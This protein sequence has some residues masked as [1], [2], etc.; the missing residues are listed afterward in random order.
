M[1]TDAQFTAWLKDT[2][3]VR[4][5]LVYAEVVTNGGV[6]TV[7][8]LS[9]FP[10]TTSD[11][12]IDPNVSFMP[13]ITGGIKITQSISIDGSV[14]MSFGDIQLANYDGSIDS[15]LD[16][17]WSMAPVSVYVGDV[18][19]QTSDFR[20]IGI[21]VASGIDS[22]GRD[23]VNIKLS[24][25]IQR[26]NYPVSD[27]KLNDGTTQADNLIPLCFG[28]CHNV[29]PVLT[30]AATSEYQVH[31]GAIAG[32]LEVR[33]N[34]VPVSFTPDVA[35]GKFT[36]NQ[37][38]VGTITASV[39]GALLP[40]NVL[41]AN[42]AINTSAWSKL[43]TTSTVV[44]TDPPFPGYTVYGLIANTTVTQHFVYS[45]V[46][47]PTGSTVNAL[48]YFKIPPSTTTTSF[49][50]NIQGKEGG[51]YLYCE[52]T[53]STGVLFK[54]ATGVTVGGGYF[55]GAVVKDVGNGWYGLFMAGNPDPTSTTYRIRI[56]W[57]QSWQDSYAG[58]GS[59]VGIYV[60]GPIMQGG[61]LPLTSSPYNTSTGTAIYRHTIADI[62]V[63]LTTGYGSSNATN[64]FDKSTDFD[65]EEMARFILANQQPV[66]I[67]L[68][69]RTNVID[70]CNQLAS[71][72]G[73]RLVYGLSG[74]KFVKLDPNS[75]SSN[76]TAITTS[77]ILE[78]SLQISS[79]PAVEASV[80]I[81][82][83][84]NWT[85][86]DTVADGVVSEHKTLY[87]EEYLTV[88]RVDT[89][90]QTNYNLFS[91]PVEQDTLLAVDTDAISEANRRL[92]IFNTQRKILKYTTFYE[93]LFEQVGGF[94]TITHPRFGLA[95]G[96]T[97]QIVSMSF[98]LT[99]PHVDFEVLI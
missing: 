47:M 16:D 71:S 11:S 88:T 40:A 22:K 84:K 21:F 35:N 18:S 78:R 27:A 39:Q 86:Q 95:S 33:D 62:V 2:S 43:A 77:D 74:A 15:W 75:P 94:Q 60:A 13:I 7:R 97:G 4:C 54:T 80:K 51:S 28:E 96:K 99:S 98:D 26:L 68:K 45:D 58:D 91:D 24:D 73:A 34:G 50:L 1:I 93:Y 5:V 14:S 48:A 59:T 85:V 20:E 82:Y 9:N 29:S 8:R 6:P 25:Q 17:Y 69:D 64:R 44:S 55:N 46:T 70:A 56:R 57:K 41:I 10:Y 19:W 67:Y 72:V 79:M 52:Y 83:C 37:A 76:T 12:D 90:A 23:T 42:P 49:V 66:G 92:A 31:N 53:P 81:G 65:F 63:A 36:L 32:I 87:A 30:N 89:T 3:A 38:S 61:T